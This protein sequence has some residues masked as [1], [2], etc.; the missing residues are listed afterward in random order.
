MRRDTHG[1]LQIPLTFL[2]IHVFSGHVHLAPA[3]T[4]VR[5][6]VRSIAGVNEKQQYVRQQTF[7]STSRLVW[8]RGAFGVEVVMDFF[9]I[10]NFSPVNSML[11][12]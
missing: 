7:C 5:M 3:H 1:H 2:Q 10:G 6:G 9:G 4:S 11:A 8:Q 12:R